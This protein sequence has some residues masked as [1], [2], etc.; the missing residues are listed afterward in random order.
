V[1]RLCGRAVLLEDGTVMADGNPA[2][3]LAQYALLPITRV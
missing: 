2:D 3:V 1:R